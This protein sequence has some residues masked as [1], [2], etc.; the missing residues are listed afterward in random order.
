MSS[1]TDLRLKKSETFFT[2]MKAPVKAKIAE[3]AESD[4]VSMSD[5]I[6]SLVLSDLR[7]RGVKIEVTEKIC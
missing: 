4:G 7:K 1:K 2:R 3:I 6:E 5:Y